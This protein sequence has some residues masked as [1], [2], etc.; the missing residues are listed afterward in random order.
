MKVDFNFESNLANDAIV[1][2]N[3]EL[4]MQALTVIADFDFIVTMASAMIT[5]S[6]IAAIGTMNR[7]LGNKGT[8]M[9]LTS[10]KLFHV[11]QPP[12][13]NNF[14]SFSIYIKELRIHSIELNFLL[15]IAVDNKVNE[16]QLL[17]I[18]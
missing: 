15:S 8:Y 16:I 18:L 14:L 13:V 11:I 3:L 12:N 9:Q 7:F 5:P 1:I 17:F 6:V 10:E 4:N 2:N